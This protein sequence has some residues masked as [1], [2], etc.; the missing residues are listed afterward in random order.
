MT[1]RGPFRCASFMGGVV[2]R[3]VTVS[4]K[5]PVGCREAKPNRTGTTPALALR[6]SGLERR[7]SLRSLTPRL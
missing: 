7:N 4:V 5:V 3:T 2:D 1:A 6:P